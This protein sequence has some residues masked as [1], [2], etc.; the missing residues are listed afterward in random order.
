MSKWT[1]R[2]EQ[3]A[4][5]EEQSNSQEEGSTMNNEV[6]VESV[7]G[8]ETAV[9]QDAEHKE[10]ST[11]SEVPVQLVTMGIGQFVRHMLLKSEKSNTEVLALVL[12]LYPEA[13]TTPACIAWYKSDLRKKGLLEGA[14][15]RGATKIIE[16][17]AE[18]L[19]E[20]IK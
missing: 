6:S 13:K 2:E 5:S 11:T 7:E 12:K 16:L 9:E 17:S 19:A 4:T 1:K 20:L 8:G 3:S 15:S 18:Q 14:K 10:Q